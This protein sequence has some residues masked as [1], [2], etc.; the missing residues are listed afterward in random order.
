MTEIEILRLQNRRTFVLVCSNFAMLLVLFF[1]FGYV[2]WQSSTLIS[3]VKE[4]LVRAEQAVVQLQ[5][6]IQQ[7]DIDIVMDKVMASAKE[8]LG[9]SVKSAVSES[10]LG[11]SLGN[12]AEKVENAQANLENSSESL[13]AANEKLQ[14]M[15]TEHLAKLVSYYMLQGLADGFASAAEANKP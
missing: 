13:K 1:G 8:S 4:D 3:K 12:L 11:G 14:N 15:D 2:L 7:A 6:T 10:E 5:Q 9:E